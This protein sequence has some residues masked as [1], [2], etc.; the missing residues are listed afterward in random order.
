MF[1]EKKK[2]DD[3]L[4]TNDRSQG[5]RVDDLSHVKEVPGKTV[6]IANPTA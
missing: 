1:D 5:T 4:K 6:R 3:D 2:S